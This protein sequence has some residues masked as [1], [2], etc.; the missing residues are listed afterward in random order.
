MKGVASC[1]R[2]NLR[3]LYKGDIYKLYNSQKTVCPSKPGVVC[4]MGLTGY[5]AAIICL[6]EAQ[7]QQSSV[8]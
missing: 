7:K 2:S 3:G 4:W 6:G 8:Y 5:Q 1:S